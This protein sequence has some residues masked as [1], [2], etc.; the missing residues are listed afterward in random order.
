MMGKIKLG[1]ILLL[2]QAVSEKTEHP[3][4]RVF[5]KLIERTSKNTPIQTLLIMQ[6]HLDKN[7]SM[8][9]W[10]PDGIPIL[11][12]NELIQMEVKKN[13]NQLALS[14]VCL[15]DTSHMIL[16]L[17]A[18]AKSLHHVR[19]SRIILWM[20]GKPTEDFL[21][22][23][24]S[25]AE[26][27]KF[28]LMLVLGH[29]QSEEVSIHRLC[30][31][32]SPHFERIESTS[33]FGAKVFFRDKLNYQGKKAIVSPNWNSSY[34]LTTKYGPTG[35]FPIRR[36]ED[37]NI[38]EFALKFNV[39]LVLAD[40]KYSKT[41][42][43]YYDLQLNPRVVSSSD[44]IIHRES[45]NAFAVSS[46]MVVVPCNRVKSITEVFHKLDVKTWLTSILYVYVTFVV[47]ESLIIVISYRISGHS[48][49][50]T[51]LNPCMNTRAFRAILGLPFPV[52]PRASVS[53]RQLF[54]AMSIFGMIFSSFFN[55][56]LSSLLTKHPLEPQVENFE[57]L[58]ESGLT[59]IAD[60]EHRSFIESVLNKEFFR[61]HIPNVQ[62][63]EKSERDRMV[64]T[65][66]DSVAYIVFA[67]YWAI[68]D[69]VQQIH[70]EKTMCKSKNLSIVESLPRMYILQKDSVYWYP[71][72]R[73]FSAFYESGIPLYWVRSFPRSLKNY[74][75]VTMDPKV[76]AAFEPL[77]LQHIK[78]LGWVLGFGYGLATLVFLVE[79]YIGNAK[80]KVASKEAEPPRDQALAAV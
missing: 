74:F 62:Y 47:V 4:M 37:K 32:P 66:N 52:G 44:L 22:Q 64:M 55:C 34:S 35:F 59:V 27:H 21:N 80:R 5:N 12:T 14:V 79:L 23:I 68:I 11:R 43:P 45:V 31:F 49:R 73:F 36:V 6:H 16:L 39:T 9:D 75:N 7:C 63:V 70:G 57:Q 58:Q 77:S 3:H 56:K 8:Q 17:N 2:A 1:L 78:W 53:L 38:I 67:E 28:L 54:L 24:S 76:E 19:H 25:Q 50:L 40:N 13:F 60:T 46:L 42:E 33:S 10:N 18:L 30:P 15:Q 29:D 51:S 61:R 72:A 71:L 20:Q 26:E 65:K 48:Y 69:S 41:T